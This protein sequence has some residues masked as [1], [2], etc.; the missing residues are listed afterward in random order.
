MASNM[1]QST[2]DPTS[3]VSKSATETATAPTAP[4][5]SISQTAPAPI[6]S[7][8][9][10]Y[11]T[12]PNAYYPNLYYPSQHYPPPSYYPPAYPN[13][14]YQNPT[15]PNQSSRT[16]NVNPEIKKVND[17]LCWSVLNIFLGGL[18]FGILPI[19][20][21]LICRS[22]K[23]KND[24]EGARKMSNLALA[25]NI[26]SSVLGIAATVCVIIY[27]A[28]FYNKDRNFYYRG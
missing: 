23:R 3:V 12:S 27:F 2:T 20:F 5:E 4:I 18:L 19:V 26:V 25:S 17:W 10:P 21:S 16:R 6:N 9:S 15:Y 8:A 22:K 7:A 1:N 14:T 13:P 24:L 11:A 28:Y